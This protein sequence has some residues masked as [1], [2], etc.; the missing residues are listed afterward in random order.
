MIDLRHGDM[1]DVLRVA[2][3][4][5]ERWHACITDPPYHL[6]SIS[7]RFGV[8]G[9]A[10]AKHGKDG[11]FARLSKGF[12]GKVWDGG[13][14]AFRPETWRAVWDV[15]HPGAYLLAFGG[16]RTAHRIAVAIEDAGFEIRDTRL[17]LYSTG[18]PKS[19]NGGP[20]WEGYGTA[21]KPAYEPI[22]EARKPLG[23]TVA[24]NLAK[25][26]C[27]ALNIDACR[28]P[29][30]DKT[31]AP[32][33][34][35]GRSAIG[36]TGHTGIRNGAADDLGRWP[37]NIMHDGS[38]DVLAAFAAFG[39]RPGQIAHARTDG[40]R[41]SSVALGDKRAVSTNPV[42]R[43]DSGT[44]AR[45]FPTLGFSEDDRRFHYCGK[46][47][48][49][50]RHGSLHPTV[51]PLSLMQWLVRLGVPRGGRVLDPFAGTGPTLEAARL[52]GFSATGIEAES[53]Y[54]QDALRRLGSVDLR[55]GPWGL[56]LA[57]AL[58]RNR[59][60]WEATGVRVAG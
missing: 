2:A 54:I 7:K 57:D 50:E 6:T 45:F 8:E 49:S 37:P 43:E 56:S 10:P 53:E 60:A 31:P 34:Q 23:G 35:Y 4:A 41:Q 32:V 27:G 16:S 12:M 33:G 26:G 52:E 48:K 30:R 40:A 55:T 46:A 22:I 36:P 5:G 3:R 44:A 19:K 15:L 29:A 1:L 51:K 59:A 13:D 21:S 14:I 24:Q 18:F 42:P 39:D 11:S 17:W 25:Y 47:R 9:A 28:V 38:D 20:G 58:A